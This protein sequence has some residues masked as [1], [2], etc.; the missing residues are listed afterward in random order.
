ME[1]SIA[2]SN[3]VNLWLG[4]INNDLKEEVLLASILQET[5]KFILSELLIGRNLTE[6]FI[7]LIESGLTIKDA[8][9][10]LLGITTSEVTA[11][12][13]KYWNL[14]NELVNMIR[15]VD[16]ID[17]CPSEFK[18]Q[19]QILDV[20]KILCESKKLFVN[21]E[22][23]LNKAIEYNLEIEPLK[24]AIKILQARQ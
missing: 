15:F 24:E 7:R 4:K 1:A 5:G 23:A 17:S 12:I 11:E 8:E 10:K 21:V 3:L 14:G 9:K 2:S 13:F 18:L 22:K 6:E 19:A 20:V 16:N